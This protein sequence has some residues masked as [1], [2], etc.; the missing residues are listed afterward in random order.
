MK[1]TERPPQK[2]NGSVLVCKKKGAAKKGNPGAK[3]IGKGAL[4]S[5]QTG[6]GETPEQKG[7]KERS[8]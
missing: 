8:S 2:K 7:L 1:K 3:A 6:A 5:L 4:W